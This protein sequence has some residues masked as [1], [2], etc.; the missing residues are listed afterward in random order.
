MRLYLAIELDITANDW[1]AGLE[2]GEE[3]SEELAL[4]HLLTWLQQC[5]L[6]A[7]GF[8]QERYIPEGEEPDGWEGEE[9]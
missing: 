1:S 5:I 4:L 3:M 9:T 6:D 7:L 8:V 2:A